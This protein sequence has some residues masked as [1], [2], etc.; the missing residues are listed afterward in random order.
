VAVELG[1]VQDDASEIDAQWRSAIPGHVRIESTLHRQGLPAGLPI[2]PLNRY[3]AGV[4]GH[5][6]LTGH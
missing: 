2:H 1:G 5:A 6:D 4:V 3:I